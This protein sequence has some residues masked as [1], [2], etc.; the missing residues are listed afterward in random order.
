MNNIAVKNILITGSGSGLG[1]AMAIRLAED[2]HNITLN[3]RTE[4]KLTETEKLLEKFNVNVSIKVGDVSSSKFVESMISE[5]VSEQKILHGVIN[6]AGIGG[7]PGPVINTS[8]ENMQKIMDINFKGTWLVSKFAAKIFLTQ[9]SLKPLRGKIINVSS[10]AGLEPMPGTGIYNCSKA[11]VNSLTHLLAKELAP[12]I[13]VN[14][15]CPGYH[16]TPIYR[17]DPEL[18]QKYWNAISMKPLL[19][20]VGTA[21]DVVGLIS[22]LVSDDS[23]YITGQIIS[24][25]GGVVLH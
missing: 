13:T 8:E 10:I 16:V 24:V 4:S 7:T 22:F 5:I 6:N 25:C 19:R 9:R 3:G 15:I 20:R 2:G 21:E 1:R 18:I 17:N 23:N 11:A 12:T 14:A